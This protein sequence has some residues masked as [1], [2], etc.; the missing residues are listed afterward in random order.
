MQKK[1][2]AAIIGTSAISAVAATQA[3]AAT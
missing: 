2:I 1:V 3:N